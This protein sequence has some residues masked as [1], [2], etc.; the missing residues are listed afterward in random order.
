[1][2]TSA[3]GHERLFRERVPL[4]PTE[5]GHV[6][7]SDPWKYGDLAEGV[8]AWGFRAAQERPSCSTAR[9]SPRVVRG[10]V[11]PVVSSLREAG[12]V[13]PTRPPPTPTSASAACATG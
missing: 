4:A 2:P 10:G 8:E 3:E 11:R 12:L 9:R 6:N 7:L 5:A 1:M 13:E